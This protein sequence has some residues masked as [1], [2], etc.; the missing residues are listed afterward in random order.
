MKTVNG[1]LTYNEVRYIMHDRLNY[2]KLKERNELKAEANKNGGK[3]ST[4]IMIM[5]YTA[6]H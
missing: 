1:E 5:Y 3:F 2:R 4:C 6:S